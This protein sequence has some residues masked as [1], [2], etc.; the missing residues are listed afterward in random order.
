MDK[1]SQVLLLLVIFAALSVV[2]YAIK[3]GRSVRARI[4]EFELESN[5]PASPV[6]PV[7]QLAPQQSE[8]VTTLPPRSYSAGWSA[9]G[10]HGP[11]VKSW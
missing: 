3:K 10:S 8:A 11:V 4:G 7:A 2:A 6:A 9:G 5:A 1:V